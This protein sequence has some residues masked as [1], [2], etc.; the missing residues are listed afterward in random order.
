MGTDSRTVWRGVGKGGEGSTVGCGFSMR[1]TALDIY[2]ISWLYF[3][4]IL[5]ERK[6]DLIITLWICCFAI[7][8]LSEI[9]MI[10]SDSNFSSRK[11]HH[12]HWPSVQNLCLTLS[13]LLGPP[14]TTP[15]PGGC[16]STAALTL[17]K[18]LRASLR[19]AETSRRE[20]GHSAGKSVPTS[21][22][23]TN[24]FKDLIFQ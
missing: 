16:H 23:T 22:Y 1:W 8:T 4:E 6:E 7:P 14:A 19:L 17:H 12:H 11:S 24:F 2:K 15:L 10:H 9:G 18:C 3:L 5:K 21:V 13:S 20:T